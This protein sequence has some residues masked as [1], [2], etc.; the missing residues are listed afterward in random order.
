[1]SATQEKPTE[2]TT[3]TQ[4]S[5]EPAPTHLVHRG[6]AYPLSEEPLV[7]G[8]EPGAHRGVELTGETAGISRIHCRVVRRDNQIWVEDSSTYGS[9]VNNARVA[10]RA[11]LFPGDQLRMGTPGIEVE[12]IAVVEVDGTT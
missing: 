3:T 9:F 1:M 7:L 11:L 12:L 2:Q 4:T 8:V 6:L 10:S 5:A